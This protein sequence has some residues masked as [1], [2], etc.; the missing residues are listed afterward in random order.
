MKTAASTFLLDCRVGPNSLAVP[1]RSHQHKHPHHCCQ[2]NGGR[3][4]PPNTTHLSIPTANLSDN[5]NTTVP[6]TGLSVPLHLFLLLLSLS[7][8]IRTKCI[9]FGYGFVLKG[10]GVVLGFDLMGNCCCGCNPSIYRVSSNVKS[11]VH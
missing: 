9:E 5:T 11:G 10:L 8:P 7:I 1:R 3:K 6:E 2:E 4:H